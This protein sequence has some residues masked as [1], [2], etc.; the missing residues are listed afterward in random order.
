[1]A[2]AR[3][4]AGWIAVIAVLLGAI[5][6]GYLVLDRLAEVGPEAG[7][8]RWL[9]PLLS[10]AIVLLSLG[11][12][13]ILIRNI[14]RLVMDRKRG[15]LGS[16]LRTKLV[17]FFLAL[18]LP[19]ALVLFYGSAAVIRMTVEG[20][21]RTPVQDLTQ[22]A[23][24]MM[25]AWTD[26]LLAQCVRQA[27]GLAEEIRIGGCLEAGRREDLV[28][29]V[30]RWRE[31]E[32]LQIAAVSVDGGEW[33]WE[34]D[35]SLGDDGTRAEDLLE[36]SAEL[37]KESRASRRA[38]SRI[39][40]VRDGL[41]AHA[42]TPVRRSGVGDTDG[43]AE[44]VVVVGIYL[45]KDLA[46]RMEKIAS[47][48]DVYRQLRIQRRDLIRVYLSLIGL[49][50]L[51]T[52][53]VATWMGFY[54]A[55]RIAVPLEEL[56]RATR[57]VA[58]G[59]LHVRVRGEVGD[60]IGRLVESFNQMA[61]QLQESREVITQSTADL[62]RSNRALEERR[63]Y[64]E[65]LVESL[66]TAVISLGADGCVTL[67]NPATERILGVRPS[68][69]VP[70][71]A[72]CDQPGLESLRELLWV[73]GHPTGKSVRQDLVLTPGG[74][75]IS[76]AVQVTPLPGGRSEPLGTL[77]MVE[78]L[79][80]F[81]RAQRA[82][83]WSEVA[84][85]IAHEIK[86]PLTPI[87]LAAQRIRKKAQEAAPDLQDVVP[88]ATA[89]IEREVQALQRMVDEFSKFAR[90]P[91]MVP[92]SVEFASVVRS[93]LSLYQGMPDIRWDV[94]SA[95]DLS[96][97]QVDSE[98]MR[99]VL[100]NLVDNAVAAMNGKGAI[101]IVTRPYAGPGSLR[102]EVTDSGPGIAPEDRHRMF[103]PYY[104]TKRRGTGLGLAIVHRVVT[105]HG[106]TV[107]IEDNAP[108]GVRFVIEIPAAGGERA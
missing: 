94:E 104:S 102:L 37:V 32:A 42:V 62:R 9:L 100:I 54:L 21:L 24:A 85:R 68:V 19:P 17:F 13:G 75:A 5:G 106:G 34:V 11:L 88:E 71:D 44:A 26:R 90:M 52:V 51:V 78:D 93:V 14:V 91:A 82:E 99:R 43:A 96:P 101:R 8:A 23:Q 87:R 55:R 73:S 76:V 15:I 33:A 4:T 38:A 41:L 80:D 3:R 47:V 48:G 65:T 67:A 7:T 61:A 39:D 105:D 53:F 27:E 107:R 83:A 98:Q 92:Q 10:A 1:M 79:T 30:A 36:F 2:H 95:P 89:S 64:I 86:N 84:R 70:T 25:D 103:V 59:N 50:F 35:P 74:K 40:H 29:V 57:E 81:L 49:I 108:Q 66:S 60:E 72:W 18:V 46:S 97:V 58:A 22:Q 28:R 16:K 56:A 31:R 6:G 45:P 77:I 20:M 63:R 69:G 12:A